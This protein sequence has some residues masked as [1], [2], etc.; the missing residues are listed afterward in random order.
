MK[1]KTKAAVGVGLLATALL[2]LLGYWVETELDKFLDD[3][4]DNLEDTD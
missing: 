3:L 4:F 1:N 2:G